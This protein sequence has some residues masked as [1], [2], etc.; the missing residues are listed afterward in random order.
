[1]K[2]NLKDVSREL[3]SS[4][5][6]GVRGFL[7]PGAN[8]PQPFP[9][10]GAAAQF[11]IGAMHEQ[12]SVSCLCAVLFW[13]RGNFAACNPLETPGTEVLHMIMSCVGVEMPHIVHPAHNS[14][15]GCLRHLLTGSLLT[16]GDA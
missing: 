16:T 10:A 15:S 5:P 3:D 8:R 1:M 12:V 7:G 13:P 14:P 4:A 9:F 2:K 6:V 11:S